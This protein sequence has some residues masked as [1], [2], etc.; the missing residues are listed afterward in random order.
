MLFRLSAGGMDDLTAVGDAVNV[1]ARLEAKSKEL[2]W[3]LVTSMATL[4]NAGPEFV[5][6]E[7]RELEL[8]GRN[9]RVVAGRL[10]VP[11]D[12]AMPHPGARFGPSAGGKALLAENARSSAVAAKVALDQTLDSIPNRPQERGAALQ[13]KEPVVRGYQVLAKIGEGGMSDVY[14]ARDE[15]NG[16][17]AVLKILRSGRTDV[18]G[19]CKRF[20]QESVILSSIRHKNVVRVYDH[21]FVG[22]LAYIAMEYLN[23]GS[24]RKLIDK[25]LSPRQALALL[26]QATGALAEIHQHG[27]VHRDLKPANLMLREGGTLVLTDFGVA[28]RLEQVVAQTRHG[29][30]LGTPFYLSPEQIQ[31]NVVS[32]S[33]DLYGLGVI[34]HEMLTGT[35]PFQ[36]CTVEEVLAQHLSAPIPRLPAALADYQSLIDGMLAKNPADRFPD[37]E[38]ILAEIDKVWTRNLESRLQSSV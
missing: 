26:S 38:A 34:F 5:V 14:L 9:A 2:G 15:A 4:E 1:A 19:L 11:G 6:A 7:T 21:G 25:G 35:R 18:E 29:E 22:D 12:A 17:R 3:P 33:A 28:K 8:A 37:A 16:R 13:Q 24:L 32:P 23:G 10:V 30:I 27:I 36:G 20:F 31:G